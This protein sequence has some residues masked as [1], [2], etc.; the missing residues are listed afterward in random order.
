MSRTGDI[1]DALE[2]IV[3]SSQTGLSGSLPAL[4][5]GAAGFERDLRAGGDLA[6]DALPH[7]FA[8]DPA[9]VRSELAHQQAERVLSI[10][11]DFW[12]F[13][14][15]QENMLTRLEACETALRADRTLG[16]LVERVE[17]TT[18]QVP[19]YFVIGKPHRVGL[20][21]VEM[22]DTDR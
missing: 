11:L 13:E 15:T 7:V 18:L 1:L 5:A 20:L 2:V 3:R 17:V 14:E 12:A 9:Q 19:D 21:L 6:V 16:G 4:T 8:H 22:E 10:Q